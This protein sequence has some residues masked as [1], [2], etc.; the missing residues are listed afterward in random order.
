[1]VDTNGSVFS[2]SNST[3]DATGA[4]FAANDVS[5]TFTNGNVRT[6]T[7]YSLARIALGSTVAESVLEPDGAL[8]ENVSNIASDATGSVVVLDAFSQTLYRFAAG[9]STAASINTPSHTTVGFVVD[10]DGYVVAMEASETN[11]SNDLVQ[12]APGSSTTVAAASN[13]LD[14]PQSTINVLSTADFPSSGTI[15]ITVDGAPITIR[16][17]GTT[18]TSFTGC[19]T[20]GTGTLLTGQAVNITGTVIDS[21]V[22][23]FT[24]TNGEVM[25]L[26]TEAGVG[27]VV[28]FAAGSQTRK[29][30]DTNNVTEMLGNI[31]GGMD[32]LEMPNPSS[33]L[34][35]LV[36]IQA[37]GAKLTYSNP[38][39]TIFS[40]RYGNL[41]AIVG[42]NMRPSSRGTALQ[43]TIPRRLLREKTRATITRPKRW[44]GDTWATP[45]AWRH[46]PSCCRRRRQPRRR[47]NRSNGWPCS[48][49]APGTT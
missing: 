24:L 10:G 36:N 15:N 8:F 47:Q 9:S 18:S 25:A 16:Y 21:L 6:T 22:Q 1:M 19:T 43:P 20:S 17:T 13:N 34:G 14:L 4:I 29:V 37:T 5:T 3:V 32:A 46:W 39:R 12:Y 48:K 31:N 33:G 28:L 26:D 41:I 23:G 45:G 40:D 30:L 38:V 44:R 27:E 2:T 11:S 7:V 42:T 35:T 49:W